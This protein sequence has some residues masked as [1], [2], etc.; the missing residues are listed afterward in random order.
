MFR[1]LALGPTTGVIL[2]IGLAG[3]PVGVAIRRRVNRRRDPPRSRRRK[4][5]DRHRRRGADLVIEALAPDR[6]SWSVRMPAD[7]R[8]PSSA[9]TARGGRIVPLLP[10]RL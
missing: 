8:Q 4:A 6:P 3:L 2:L 10:G 1:V 9:A 5:A 7:E